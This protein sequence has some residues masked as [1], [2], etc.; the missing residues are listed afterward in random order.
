MN[1]NEFRGEKKQRFPQSMNRMGSTSLYDIDQLPKSLSP[2]SGNS[3]MTTTTNSPT[4]DGYDILK[5]EEHD[6]LIPI[7]FSYIS[8]DST[9]SGTKVKFGSLKDE[10]EHHRF[11]VYNS[12]IVERKVT[13]KATFWRKSKDSSLIPDSVVNEDYPNGHFL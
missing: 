13:E 11:Q 3:D 7:I 8:D 4:N 6:R 12:E 1:K 10:Q 2:E 9:V 5:C